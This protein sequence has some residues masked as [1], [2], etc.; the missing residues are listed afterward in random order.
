MSRDNENIG[1]NELDDNM[2]AKHIEQCAVE[3]DFW[4]QKK[5]L[6]K[7]LSISSDDLQSIIENSNLIVM[8][9]EGELTTRKLYKKKTAFSDRLFNAINNKIT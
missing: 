5:K 7:D 2:I 9:S 1:T 8:N 3:G 6:F 4:L